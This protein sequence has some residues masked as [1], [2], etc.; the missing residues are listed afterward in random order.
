MVLSSFPRLLAKIGLSGAFWKFVL[1]GE[2][3][4]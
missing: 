1:L 2:S 3:A 4:L